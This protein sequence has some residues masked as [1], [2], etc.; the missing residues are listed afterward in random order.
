MRRH[1]LVC[2]GSQSEGSICSHVTHTMV[3][4][5]DIISPLE[6]WDINL[7]VSNQVYQLPKDSKQLQEVNL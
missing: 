7:E 4:K 3:S 1:G 6:E 5:S 2:T